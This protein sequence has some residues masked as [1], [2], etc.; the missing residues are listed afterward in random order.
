MNKIINFF[1]TIT[2]KSTKKERL[3]VYIIKTLQPLIKEYARVEAESGIFLPP[4][5]KTD[6]ARWLETLRA[7][8]YSFDELNKEFSG[9]KISCI[10]DE[11]KLEE[12]AKKIQKGLELFGKYLM[13]LN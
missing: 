7:M 3:N 10:N 11:I 9:E 4:D 12:R 6:P 13:D 8:E 5:F 2:G 1:R